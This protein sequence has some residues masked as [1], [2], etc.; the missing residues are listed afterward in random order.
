MIA[1]LYQYS[2]RIR[3]RNELR[4]GLQITK[5]FLWPEIITAPLV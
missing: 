4:Q 5:S 3:D 1:Y 2:K